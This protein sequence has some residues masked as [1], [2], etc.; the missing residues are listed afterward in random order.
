MQWLIHATR[1]NAY[2]PFYEQRHSGQIK[3][4]LY[5]E[6]DNILFFDC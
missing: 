5:D 2:C 4:F 3:E 6:T 1:Q